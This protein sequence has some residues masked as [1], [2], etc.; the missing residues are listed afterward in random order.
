MQVKIRL[1]DE[2]NSLSSYLEKRFEEGVKK[3]YFF[4]S[5]IKESGFNLIEEN[6]IDSKA[7]IYFAI[8][9]DKKYTT[10]TMLELML[11]YTKDV[12]VHNNNEKLEY[13]SNLIFL[14]YSDRAILLAL[15]DSISE[16]TLKTYKVMYTECIYNFKDTL[17]KERYKEN[18]KEILSKVE[19]NGFIKLDRNKVQ[20]LS[21]A[22]QIFST[23]Q[24]MHNVKSISELL[25]QNKSADKPKEEVNEDVGL[26]DVIG[27]ENKVPKVDLSGD[28]MDL[29]EIELPEEE[30]VASESKEEKKESI[31]FDL[32]DVKD[33]VIT[34]TNDIKEEMVEES[35]ITEDRNKIDNENELYDEELA[36]FDFDE[37]DTLDIEGMLFEKSDIKLEIKSKTKQKD[38]EEV[39]E[40]EEDTVQS[41]K[42]D[43][44]NIS[45]LLFELPKR[46]DK[47]KEKS[48]LKIPNYINNMIP[49]FLDL[50]DKGK[51]IEIDNVKYKKRNVK[52][53]V[54]NVST[55]EKFL[56]TNA[57]ISMKRGQTYLTIN[58][59][60]LLNVQYNENDIARIIKLS[61][62]TYHIE[63]ISK[64]IQEYKLWK[65]LCNQ[66][67]KMTT[68]MY[69]IM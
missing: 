34:I 2:E 35:K 16:E 33:S 53:E 64:D 47:Q 14:E 4:C 21:D 13:S 17:E 60:K 62:D 66:N 38:K 46:S 59:D 43:L 52:L 18:L 55:R 23:K 25:G 29:F 6:F 40:L 41:K 49:N 67:M 11:K 3:A 51:N 28:F 1:Q 22:K 56:D 19:E 44:N 36:N 45:N 61:D 26:D 24:Y 65:K 15:T 5:T 8:G 10:K 54:V 68:R 63:I 58:T 30:I 12:Y 9:V 50:E 69:G 32:S 20:E 27:S 42:V 31:D 57:N 37:N 39:V 7:K 48:E